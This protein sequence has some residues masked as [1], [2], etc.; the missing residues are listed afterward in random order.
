M[1]AIEKDVF[2]NNIQFT[3][4]DEERKHWNS[5]NQHIDKDSELNKWIDEQQ[6]KQSK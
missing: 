5:I 3:N 2:N 4:Y 1:A 6:D